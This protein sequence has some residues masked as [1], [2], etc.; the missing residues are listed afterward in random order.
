M[1]SGNLSRTLP[2]MC[3]YD[4][5][6]WAWPYEEGDTMFNIVNTYTKASQFED[7]SAASSFK[8]QKTGGQ[9]LS[10]LKPL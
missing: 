6:T 2:E 8:L 1:I 7:L 4:A 10:M 9:I 3:L 5:V